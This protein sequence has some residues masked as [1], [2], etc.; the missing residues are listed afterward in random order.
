MLLCHRQR[1]IT[2]ASCMPAMH[3]ISWWPLGS[4]WPLSATTPDAAV[5]TPVWHRSALPVLQRAGPAHRGQRRVGG[6]AVLTTLLSQFS[7]FAIAFCSACSSSTVNIAVLAAS[8][9][10]LLQT[11]GSKLFGR[12]ELTP[13]RSP[14]AVPCARAAECYWVGRAGGALPGR[15][16]C[17]AHGRCVRAD[18]GRQ[19]GADGRPAGPGVQISRAAG[20]PTQLPLQD[21]LSRCCL[22]RPRAWVQRTC[23]L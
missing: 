18:H 19:A 9:A 13:E 3:Q 17:G 7:G 14:A 2:S 21:S 20:L 1:C 8:Q 16:P 4:G 5:P 6:E 15:R 22:S 11:H 23:S 12:V 10:E